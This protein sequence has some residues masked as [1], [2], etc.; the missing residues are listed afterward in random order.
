MHSARSSR[1]CVHGLDRDGAQR[2]E[3]V[4]RIPYIVPEM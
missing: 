4:S 3:P 2:E 1:V